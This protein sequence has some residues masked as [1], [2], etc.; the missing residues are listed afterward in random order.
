ML[1]D[2]LVAFLLRKEKSQIDCDR[3]RFNQYAALREAVC[4]V[5]SEGTQL[6]NY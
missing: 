6:L 1:L 2:T 3:R 4:C 5:A